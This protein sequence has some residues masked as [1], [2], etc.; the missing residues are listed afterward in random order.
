[1]YCN[2]IELLLCKHVLLVHLLVMSMTLR[3]YYGLNVFPHRSISLAILF[4][5][6][7]WLFKNF[8][9][10]YEIVLKWS[11]KILNFVISLCGAER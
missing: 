6:R 3:C 9:I 11:E 4:P 8:F 2:C 5:T 10:S 7:V 1:M